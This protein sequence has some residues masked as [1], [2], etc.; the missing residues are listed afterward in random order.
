VQSKN[1]INPEDGNT[2]QLRKYRKYFLLYIMSSARRCQHSLKR[3][4]QNLWVNDID[5]GYVKSTYITSTFWK[6]TRKAGHL[7]EQGIYG[8]ISINWGLSCS[9][10]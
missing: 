2:K 3:Y 1:C 8:K 5:F 4:F 9:W 10:R 6:I 7:E